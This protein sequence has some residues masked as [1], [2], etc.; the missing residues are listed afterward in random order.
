MGGQKKEKIK[1]RLNPQMLI[2]RTN[3][4]MEHNSPLQAMV[5]LIGMPS[6]KA[7]EAEAKYIQT[8]MP[9]DNMEYYR[10]HIKKDSRNFQNINP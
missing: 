3:I 8:F 10:H 4:A 1:N 2:Q 7:A 9:K 5:Y 6:L